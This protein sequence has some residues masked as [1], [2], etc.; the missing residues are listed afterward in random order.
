M[1]NTKTGRIFIL[2][3]IIPV[4]WAAVIAA[5]FLSQGLLGIIS[6]LTQSLNDPLNFEWCANTL[7]SI[8]MFLLIYA[9]SIGI[10][11]STKRNYR[12]GEEHGSAKWGVVSILNKKYANRK[13]T[14]NKILTKNFKL[15]LDGRKHKRNINVLVVGGSGAG[16]TRFYAKPN[17]MQVNTSFVCLDPKAEI[18]KSTGHL[19]EQQGY[20]IK[21]LDL[22]DMEKSHGYNPF[23]YLHD[24]KDV[25]KLV[26]S[27]IRNTTP[28][29][30]QSQDP[31]WERAEQALMET[32]MLY[33][34]HEAPPHEQNFPM[35][36]ELINAAEVKEEDEEHVSILD[37]LFERLAMRDPEHIA[38]KQ[39]HIF[40]L[41]AGETKFITS[42]NPI[43]I[44]KM[45]SRHLE[46][47]H[48]FFPLTKNI[49]CCFIKK[50]GIGKYLKI[51]PNSQNIKYIN[52]LIFDTCKKYI[53]F[54]KENVFDYIS[55]IPNIN[56]WVNDFKE[57]GLKF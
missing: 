17:I 44:N 5:P 6:G 53:V 50:P 23:V 3:G 48:I 57:I 2:L 25:L 47:C 36:M 45:S 37:E 14:G 29:G 55:E 12:K 35:V 18:L 16:K 7:K 39:Y 46:F 28:K 51:S 31:F 43:I 34:K 8:V 9:F 1:D 10:Y 54:D 56:S 38:V 42:D 32:L 24:D 33:L 15:G 22:I 49:C 11:Y 20:E 4:V 26:N 41:A 19:L 21:V 30:S 52:H 13:Y 40:K 27:I